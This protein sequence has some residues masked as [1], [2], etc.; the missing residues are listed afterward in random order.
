MLFFY[1]HGHGELCGKA[2]RCVFTAAVSS[3]AGSEAGGGL[4]H[5]PAKPPCNKSSVRVLLSLGYI[6]AVCGKLSP[7]CGVV[8]AR[9]RPGYISSCVYD[10]SRK[11]QACQYISNPGRHVSARGHERPLFLKSPGILRA[12]TVRKRIFPDA[13]ASRRKKGAGRQ[14]GKEASRRG[15]YGVSK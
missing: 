7:P 9:I 4:K 8:K 10:G 12:R 2:A 5:I 3:S 13:C 6:Y 15:D 11:Q 1:P 14:C